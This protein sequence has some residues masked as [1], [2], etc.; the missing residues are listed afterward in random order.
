MKHFLLYVPVVVLDIMNRFNW[1]WDLSDST[2]KNGLK[3]MTT[4]SCGGGSSMGYK[5]AGYDV[6]ANV[7]IDKKINDMYVL[8]NHPKYNYCMDL[9]EFNKLDD[10]PEE[11]YNLDILDGSPPCTVFSSVGKRE[12]G[13]GKSKKFREGQ[14]EQTLD[15][16]FFVFLDTV[17]KLKPKIVVA[18]NVPGLIAGNARGYVNQILHRFHNI[19]YDVQMFLLNS[20][21]M[22]VPQA[23]HRVFF[24]ANRCG[25]KKLELNFNHTPYLFGSVRSVVGSG[26]ASNTYQSLLDKA[27]KGDKKFEDVYFRLTGK[28]GM[29]F[30]SFIV[31]DDCVCPTVTAGGAFARLYDKSLFAVDDFRHT[32]SFPDDYDFGDNKAQYVCGMSVPVN[33]MANISTEIYGQWLKD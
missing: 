32:A 19:G 17:E 24:I 27:Q 31:D 29:Y 5:R 10:L 12:K 1:K 4:F 15:D 8:N 18:E 13:W 11:L 2:C 9:R 6:I 25:Y 16:L 22:D 30:S 33:M 14:T 21:F 23:R 26:R 7:E 3:V 28:K 20:A